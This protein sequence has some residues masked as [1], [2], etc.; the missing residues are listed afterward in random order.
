MENN[1]SETFLNIVKGLLSEAYEGVDPGKPVWFSDSGEHS[2]M[3]RTLERVSAETASKPLLE[4]GTT[5]AAHAEH[6]R[7]S[8]ALTNAFARGEAPAKMDWAESWTVKNVDSSAWEDLKTRLQ[9]EYQT[10][11][12]H[13]PPQPDLSNPMFVTSAVAMVA[14]AAYHLSAMRQMLTVLERD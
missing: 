4:G 9:A 7:W 12:T 6:L 11:V 8:L 3:F 14:H 10:V 2:G 13:M 1:Q 5:I